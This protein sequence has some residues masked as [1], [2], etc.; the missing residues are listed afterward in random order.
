MKTTIDK[1]DVNP[2]HAFSPQ[3]FRGFLRLLPKELLQDVSMVRLSSAIDHSATGSVAA[4]SRLEKRLVII[5]RGKKRCEV[6]FEVIK[7]LARANLHQPGEKKFVRLPP[8]EI[9]R[10]ANELVAEIEAKMPM[11][12]H[13]NRA[14][15]K[16]VSRSK[17]ETA[18]QPI[19]IDR[20]KLA[21]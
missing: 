17:P 14:E 10:Y 5:S 3:E 19:S 16:Y 15:L 20:L 8:A 18:D 6:M 21:D 9:L 2:P 12:P 11:A 13:W 4:F 1:I 7:C